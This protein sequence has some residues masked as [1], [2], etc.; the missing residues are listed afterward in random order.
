MTSGQA[1]FD[2]FK[3]SIYKSY[4][5]PSGGGGYASTVYA[6]YPVTNG[7]DGN[8][9]T[10]WFSQ[11]TGF[12][13]VVGYDFG[14]GKTLNSITLAQGLPQALCF[15]IHDQNFPAGPPGLGNRCQGRLIHEL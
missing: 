14:S 13:H 3:L 15:K 9:A 2:N 11:A 5:F 7:F 12:P 8:D 1:Y 10:A 6:G 4:L